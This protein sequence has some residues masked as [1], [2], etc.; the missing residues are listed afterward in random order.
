MIKDAMLDKLLAGTV[1]EQFLESADRILNSESELIRKSAFA[2]LI[3]AGKGCGL[4]EYARIFSAIVDSSPALSIRGTTTYLELVFPKDNPVDE[5][6]FFASPGIAASI[7]NRFYGTFL[8]SFSEYSGRDLIQSES[9]KKLIEFMEMNKDNI[10][11]L[12]HITPEFAAKD[13]LISILRTIVSITEIRLDTPDTE[14][15]FNY[16][17]EQLDNRGI[18][19]NSDAAAYIKDT[20]L[21][22]LVS[23]STYAGYKSLD[24]F[25]EKI[26]YDSMLLSNAKDYAINLSCIEN[27]M[28]ERQNDKKVG[29][30]IA[31]GFRV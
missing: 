27:Y 2:P 28:K 29:E 22:E 13:Q 5:K 7:R 17:M 6:K 21:P 1:T 12:F 31:I 8:I 11:F 25:V 15:G 4:A 10:H 9:L 20:A 30:S 26:N 16:V 3:I 23:G 19:I 24:A 18:I 14:I